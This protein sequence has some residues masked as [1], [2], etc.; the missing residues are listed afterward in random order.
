MKAVAIQQ[1]GGVDRLE[2]LDLP[3]PEPRPGE[4]L[5]RVRAAALNR[6][7]LYTIGGIAGLTLPMP[8]VV[9]SDA[10]GVVEKLG[11]GVDGVAV[12]DR[13]TFNPGLYDSTCLRCLAGEESECDRYA[14]LGEHVSG[15]M[16]QYARVPAKNLYKI[17]ST[18]SFEHAAA[19]SL[20][21]QTAWRMVVSKAD[22]KPGDTVVVLGA[23]S[24]L[25]TAAIQVAA[26]CGARVIATS[27]SDEK[28]LRAKEL[29]ASDGVN[30]RTEDWS[31]RVWQL[32][33][34]RGAD[35][36]VDAI[37]KDTLNASVRA[38]RKGGTI[39][40][41][42][43]TS[44]QEVDLDLRYVFWKQVNLRGSTMGNAREY[45]RAMDLVSAGRLKPVVGGVYPMER[46]REAFELLER[47]GH[48]GKLVVTL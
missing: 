39:T 25:S 43:G 30:Y 20:V 35:L 4:V 1:H 27:S 5:L 2:L 48:F 7:D 11:P 24:G 6:L 12:G 8:H 41:P 46:A 32:T 38:V 37:G 40:I 16:A 26:L 33:D 10:A 23:G 34:K 14:I 29:G 22:V 18:L 28:L 42:G 19:A 15:A 3:V 31:K 21:F 45:R 13:V 9:G 36:I 44:G 47:G 17:P